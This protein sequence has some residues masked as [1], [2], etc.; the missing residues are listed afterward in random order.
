[1]LKDIEEKEE[2][3]LIDKEEIDE[4]IGFFRQEKNLKIMQ[5]EQE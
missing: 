1:M 4:I 2:N 5:K 3:N